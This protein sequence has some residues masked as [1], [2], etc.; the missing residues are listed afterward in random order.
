LL[1]EATPGTVQLSSRNPICA[2]ARRSPSVNVVAVQ[3]SR[4]EDHVEAHDEAAVVGLAEIDRD[5]LRAVGGIDDREQRLLAGVDGV[6]GK[7]QGL[8][9]AARIDVQGLGRQRAGG[10]QAEQ[11]KAECGKH[12]F[13]QMCAVRSGSGSACQG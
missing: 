11:R 1:K 13:L 10:E 9:G 7:Q 3:V 8:A 4:G 12:E 6:V 2:A 5:D